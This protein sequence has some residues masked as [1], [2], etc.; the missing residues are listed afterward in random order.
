MS[1]SDFPTLEQL[2]LSLARGNVT[3]RQLVEDCLARIADPDGEGARAF[4]R[5]DPAAA[6][7]S[8]D[9]FDTLRRHGAVPS[10]FA[11]IP[12]SIKDLF[13]IEGQV[14]TAGS[15]VLA[16]A[17]PATTDASTVQ[18]LRRAGF[19]LIGRSN[20]P[21]FALSG[22]GLN[23]HYGTPTCQ[24]QRELERVPGGS[25]SGAAVSVADGMAHAALG[26]DT[27]GSCRIPA[28][29]NG[30]V[31]FKPTAR[32]VPMDG[33]VPL[34][35][36]LDAV[37]PLARSVACC[38]SLYAILC[39]ATETEL[40]T[41]PMAGL[42]LGL[43]QTMVTDGLDEAVGDAFAR[44]LTRL[45]AAGAHIV[46]VPF[47]AFAGV[48]GMHARGSLTAAESLVW[49]RPWIEGGRQLYDP[50][51]LE[52]IER[53]AQM[54]AVDYL[55]LLASRNR[56][57]AAVEADACG[58]DAIIMPTCAIIPPRIDELGDSDAFARANLMALRN[59]A[60]VNL[61]DGCSISLPMHRSGD[62]PCG[63]MLSSVA[64][65]DRAL[66]AVA[67]SVE[68]ALDQAGSASV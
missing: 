32:S 18:R 1:A 66:L 43:P 64:G 33:L 55:D 45:S 62:P 9:A 67:R 22:L 59:T 46:S 54:T 8:A 30:V 29:F 14:T 28:A 41:L 10:R 12:I 3:S 52:R 42:R 39:N 23:P 17:P 13:D 27:A 63:L 68:A 25:S 6:L 51:V 7:A 34:A 31:G 16:A 38:A 21:E 56:F 2:A 49:H 4:S 50:R 58:L 35:P 20:M 61:F 5:V 37:G 19:V 36:S 26:T 11:G 15:R 24:W 60:L 57:I 44:A 47:A 53:G 40:K 65:R 48:P